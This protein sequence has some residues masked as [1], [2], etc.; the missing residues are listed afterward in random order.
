LGVSW[1]LDPAD[2][3][4]GWGGTPPEPAGRTRHPGRARTPRR[5]EITL[6]MRHVPTGVQVEAKAAGPFAG[7]EAIEAEERLWN[8]L[9]S[10]LEADVARRLGVERG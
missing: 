7:S 10:K 2:V 4:W 5:S 9:W 6:R 8:Q 1:R 3:I